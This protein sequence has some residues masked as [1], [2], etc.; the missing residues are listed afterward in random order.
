M[1]ANS[2]DHQTV[3]KCLEIGDGKITS[4]FL[5]M[6][7]QADVICHKLHNDP[8]Y[9]GKE[10]N[11][12]GISQGGLIARTV[13]ETCPDLDINVLYTFG[14]PLGGVSVYEHCHHWYCPFVNH[15]LGYL[16][17]FAIVEDFGAPPD[18][19]R[20]WW[21]LDRYFSHT[22]FLTRINNEHEI[23]DAGYKARLTSVKKFGMW[24]WEQ[25]TV[26]VPRD[27]EWFSVW[28]GNR[29]LVPIKEQDMYTQDFIGLK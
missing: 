21:N 12:L 4:M 23:K 29:N 5:E 22:K 27:S 11:L 3:V 28:D 7:L 2:L 17:G 19:Y 14:G 8:D 26:V 9:A 15:L 6:Q 10:I 13:V 20:P 25:D 1:I 24:M 16:A 18:Y